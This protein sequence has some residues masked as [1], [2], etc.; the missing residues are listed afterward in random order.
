MDVKKAREAIDKKTMKKAHMLCLRHYLLFPQCT[1]LLV[2]SQLMDLTACNQ[3]YN[4]SWDTMHI[5]ALICPQQ[6]TSF[7]L[8]SNE[9]RFANRNGWISRLCTMAP[10]KC[11]DWLISNLANWIWLDFHYPAK[12]ASS[13]TAR[14]VPDQI[15]ANYC[16]DVS[17]TNWQS[18]VSIVWLMTNRQSVHCSSLPS[19]DTSWALMSVR[20][21]SPCTAPACW[22]VTQA[23]LWSLYKSCLHTEI[24]HQQTYPANES[25]APWKTSSLT[26]VITYYQTMMKFLMMKENLLK[27]YTVIYQSIWPTDFV[28]CFTFMLKE[29]DIICCNCDVLWD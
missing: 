12:P 24:C 8:T 17:Q 20:A 10:Y 2:I 6:S 1:L 18:S 4:S 11:I 9:L 14:F 29:M 22:A 5:N 13:Q 26:T 23:E 16:V 7:P 28:P 27:F 19:S 21:H 15:G 25:S 3:K